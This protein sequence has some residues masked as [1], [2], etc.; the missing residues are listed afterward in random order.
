MAPI[1]N[2]RSFLKL[3]AFSTAGL[4]FKPV[5]NLF[6]SN[7]F[8]TSDRL[9]RVNTSQVELKNRPDED[10]P[11]SDTLGEDSVVEWLREVVGANRGRLNQRWVETPQGYI[12]SPQLQPV[13]NYPNVPVAQLPDSSHGPGMW[14]EVSIP[15]VDLRLD[16]PPARA[17]WLV[18]KVD[19]HI[20]PR[21]YYS[22]IIWVD[23]LMTDVDGQI[24]Y[25]LNEPYGSYGDIFWARAEA[26]RPL[27]PEDFS[28]I[29]P[30][31]SEKRIVVDVNYQ[32]MSCFEGKTEVFFTR[33]SSGAKFDYLG[34]RV[35]VWET[36]VGKYPIW[37]KLVS[38]HMSGGTTGGG[39]DLPGIGWVSLFIG[40]GVAIHSTF[41]HNNFGVPMSNGCVNARPEDAQWVFRWS[42]PPVPAD[43]GDL[44]VPWPGGTIIEVVE[45]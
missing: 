39:W 7:D 2:R 26:F 22:Q 38:L 13:R 17:P 37:R 8:P 34:N 14:V 28:T 21:L 10:S 12:W 24:W 41:W 6:F 32:T 4:A 44:S 15:Y 35:D 23:R 25:H 31:A 1:I 45:T 40:S 19:H 36:P 5:E 9:G 33:I 30:E 11:S 20:T 43:P 16:N 3:A 18:Y 27:T 29:N 42:Q